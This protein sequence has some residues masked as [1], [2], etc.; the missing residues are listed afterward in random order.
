MIRGRL[1]TQHIARPFHQRGNFQE[2]IAIVSNAH[3][4]MV[5]RGQAEPVVH[6]LRGAFVEPHVGHRVANPQ[7]RSFDGL[8]LTDDG[9]QSSVTGLCHV[10][11]VTGPF[12]T[13]ASTDTP[14]PHLP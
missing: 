1:F 11:I 13:V 14:V 5:S 8:T 2:L 9:P 6:E 3:R 7:N 12:R 10:S 4:S